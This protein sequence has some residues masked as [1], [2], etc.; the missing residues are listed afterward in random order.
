MMEPLRLRL[1]SSRAS[2]HIGQQLVAI[3]T[4]LLLCFQLP[5]M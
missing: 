2:L 3:S 5:A 1:N 4:G